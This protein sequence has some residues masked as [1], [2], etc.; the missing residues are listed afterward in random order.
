MKS[1]S[2]RADAFR[3]L[4]INV[5]I[6]TKSRF[7][8]GWA[9]RASTSSTLRTEQAVPAH[10]QGGFVPGTVQG[11]RRGAPLCGCVGTHV[12]LLP[13][14]NDFCECL[15]RRISLVISIQQDLNF[16]TVIRNSEC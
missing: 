8:R 9:M 4:S 3:M 14:N 11:R 2:A 15:I 7:E 6:Q 10:A 16:Q 13:E 5:L 12:G 1:S